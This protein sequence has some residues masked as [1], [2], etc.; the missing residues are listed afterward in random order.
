MLT[1]TTQPAPVHAAV[2]DT[3]A[4]YEVRATFFVCGEMADYNRDLLTRMADKGHWPAPT[5]GPTRG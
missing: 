1:S 3:L 2:L 5:P 4:K